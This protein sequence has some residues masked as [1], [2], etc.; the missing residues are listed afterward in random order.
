[1]EQ[2][3]LDEHLA[4]IDEQG[5]TIIE[6]AI[7]P[8]LVSELR[9]T[10][11]KIHVDSAA[12]P[13]N[14]PAEGWST[15][16]LYNLLA[17]AAVFQR[18]PVHR[19]VLPF[20][21]ALLGP[22]C[23]ISGMTSMDIGP[24]EKPQMIHADD[25]ALKIPKPHIPLMVTTIWAITDF[26]D[27][28]GGTRIVPGSHRSDD[29]DYSKTHESQAAVMKAGSVL[30]LHGSTWHGG[31]GNTT[32]DVWR[33]GINMQYCVGFVR[34]QQNQPLSIPVDVAKTFDERLLR[35]CGYYLFNGIMGHV[36]GQSPGAALGID[37]ASE[38]PYQNP[39]G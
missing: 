21:E 17:K 14:T 11:R 2:A 6:D 33:L 12:A 19:N 36:D 27:E 4:A 31:G 34:Q 23:M 8:V 30:V 28:S 24:T 35:L 9:E 10:I 32:D 13:R 39:K 16:R 29:P 37:A 1:M 18:V 15:L 25:Y 7:E 20:A 38:R 26:T 5:Y 22:E 3:A